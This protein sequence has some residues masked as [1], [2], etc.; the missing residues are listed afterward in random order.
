MF[1]RKLTQKN[2]PRKIESINSGFSDHIQHTLNLSSIDKYHKVI[3]SLRIDHNIVVRPHPSIKG[4][5]PEGYKKLFTVDFNYV[6]QNGDEDNVPLYVLADLMLFDYGGPMFGALYL[7]KNFAFLEMD[8][9]AKN[10]LYLGK[11][12][13]EDYFKSFFPD[14]IAKPENLKF[15][16]NYCLNNPPSNSVVKSLREEFFNLNYQGNSAKRAYELLGS[17]HWLK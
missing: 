13:S 16:C 17:N 15:I 9:E 6:D 5:D 12:S 10:H 14:R 4:T 2:K 7:N 8:L 11:M 3:S 1:S